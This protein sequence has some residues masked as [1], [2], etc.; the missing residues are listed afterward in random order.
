MSKEQAIVETM[1]LVDEM[2]SE[3]SG[4]PDLSNEETRLAFEAVLDAVTIQSISMAETALQ[5]VNQA[6]SAKGYSYACVPRLYNDN[7][8]IT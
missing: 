8:V 5:L 3:K 4:T 6:Y 2:I 7:I 1:K